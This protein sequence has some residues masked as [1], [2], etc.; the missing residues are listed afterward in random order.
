VIGT[1]PVLLHFTDSDPTATAADFTAT[2]SWG[3]GF[4]DSSLNNS[5]SS[6]YVMA[7]PSG[8]FDVLGA[9]AYY[10]PFRQGT[11]SVQVTDDGGASLSASNSRFGVDAPLTAGTLTVPAVT[12]E[13]QSIQNAVLFHFTD[14]DPLGQASDFAATVAWGDGTYSNSD[15]GTGAVAVVANSGGGF[16]VV[17]SHT[18]EEAAGGAMFK[19]QVTDFGGAITGAQGAMPLVADPAVV[20]T[21]GFAVHAVEGVNPGMSSEVSVPDQSLQNVVL[22]HFTGLDPAATAADYVAVVDWGDGQV[23]SSGDGSV[24]VVANAGG[25]FDVVGSHVYEQAGT[26]PVGVAV[27][28]RLA[29]FTDPAGAEDVGDYTASID[30]G[31]GTTSTGVIAPS[32]QTGSPTAV[33]TI[34][35]SHQYAEQGSYTVTVTVSHDAAPTATATSTA[36]VSDPALVGTGGFTISAVAGIVSTPQT[37]ATFTDPGGAEALRHYGATIDWGDGT[38]SPGLIQLSANPAPLSLAGNFVAGSGA[39]GLVTGDLNGDGKT[40]LVVANAADG[41]VSVF[42]GNGDGSFRPGQSF[43][44]GGAPLGLSLADLNGD[45]KL[46]LITADPAGTV[47]VFLVNGDGTFAPGTNYSVAAGAFALTEASLRNNGTRDLLALSPE[48]VSA[49]LG[50]GDG[51]FAAAQTVWFGGSDL[52]SFAVGDADGDGYPDLAVTDLADSTVKILRGNGDGTFGTA[53]SYPVNPLPSSVVL[54]DLA[55]A[56]KLDLAVASAATDTVSVLP[57]H[58]DG[59]FGSATDYAVGTGPTTLLAADV[60]GDGKV[61]LVTANTGSSDVS[62]LAG[63]GDGTFQA[64]TGVGVSAPSSALTASALTGDRLDLITASP[65]S[66]TVSVLL[67]AYAVVGSHSYPARGTYPI[68]VTLNHDGVISTAPTSTARVIQ[69]ATTTAVTSSSATSTSA[70]GQDVTFTATVTPAGGGTPTGTV[71]FYLSGSPLGSAVSLSGGSATLDAGTGLVPAGYQVTAAYGGSTSLLPSSS[72]ALTYTVTPAPLTVTA[73]NL[74][75]V[76]GSPVPTLTGTLTGV[77]NGDNIPATYSTSATSSSDVGTYAITATLNDPDGRLSNYGVTNN[78]GTLTISKAD[79]AITWANPADIVYGTALGAAQLDATV[80]VVGP[81]PAGTLT[82]S[83]AAGTVLPAGGG[84]VLSVTAAATTDYNAATRPV[85]INVAKASPTIGT[86]ASPSSG[87]L[88]AVTLN[89]AATLSGGYNEIGSI[90]FALYAPGVTSS[91]YATAT[92]VFKTTVPV[93]GDGTYS[94]ATG[95]VPTAAGTYNWVDS[96]G[97]DGNTNAVA[98]TFGSDPATVT[99]FSISGSAYDDLTEN[100]F[101][102]DDPKLSTADVNYVSVTINLYKDGGTTPFATT[103]TDANGKYGF[104]GLPA[105]SYSA[106]E[107]VPGGWKETANRGAASGGPSGTASVT[108]TGGG[109]SAGNDFDNFK[110]GQISGSVFHD[111]TGDGFSAD[112]PALTSVLQAVTLKLFMNGG[113]TPFATT[114]QDRSG[115]YGFTGLDYGTYSVQEVVPAG[116]VQ[117]AGRGAAATGTVTAASGLNSAGNDFD[118]AHVGAKGSPQSKGYWTNRGNSTITASDIT[119][120]NTLNLRDGKGN[121]VTFSTTSIT[122]ARAQVANFLSGASSAN[123]ANMLSAQLAALALNVLHGFVST[124]SVIYDPNLAA[125]SSALN[126]AAVGGAGALYNGGFITVGNMINAVKNE[127]GLYGNPTQTQTQNGILVYNF[128]NELQVALNSANLN[129]NFVI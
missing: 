84:Q 104:T 24:S 65:G 123:P 26:H 20:P 64:A 110:Y 56:G 121:L 99:T 17:G 119:T 87:L 74:G 105:G 36:N 52:S 44:T 39:T 13:G 71:Q 5:T 3:D 37:V 94:P 81:A 4:H 108:A 73:D 111:L 97:G 115:L 100:G 41:S 122:T 96:Y 92:P 58:G 129:Q 59:T 53:T 114:T 107:V 101:S 60:N 83:P 38:T 76:Y 106:S 48:G 82:Y 15:D 51:T 103:S 42:L 49:L 7:D 90:T 98:S 112:D 33:F 70:Y 66:G 63:N 124:G 19:V 95:Y 93:N 57:G 34:G 120:L 47:S 67:P 11:F 45:G 14:T 61:D 18:F 8:G 89:D 40:D 118:D 23:S 80:S 22:D 46:D 27:L 68:T 1:S 30:W 113:A 102:A 117:T 126:S 12:T 16:D 9:H 88:G 35:G 125:Y 21:G 86:A 128:E 116:W 77:V 28:N 78:S 31:D 29:T 6:A 69:A 55:H 2:I 32:G 50:N 54:A 127:L 72:A 91:T 43:R 75:M 25:G 10:Q 62:V 109:S 79:Q 85:T